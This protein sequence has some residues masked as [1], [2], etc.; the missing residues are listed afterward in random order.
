MLIVNHQLMQWLLLSSGSIVAKLIRSTVSLRDKS[1]SGDSWRIVTCYGPLWFTVATSTPPLGQASLHPIPLLGAYYCWDQCDIR[2]CTYVDPT[3]WP[4]TNFDPITITINSP[5]S[6]PGY[7][8]WRN[9][10]K[11]FIKYCNLICNHKLKKKNSP[12]AT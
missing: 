11:N 6:G 1:I 4:L 9:W 7:P 10:A 2:A 5:T 3:L 8:Q 12:D